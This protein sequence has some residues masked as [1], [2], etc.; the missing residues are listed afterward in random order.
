MMMRSLL[1]AS[2]TTGLFL[3]AALPATANTPAAFDRVIADADNIRREAREVRE[4][5][6]DRR[7]SLAAVNDRVHMIDTRAQALKASVAEFDATGLS[8]AQVT[9][10]DRARS[11]TDTLLALLNNKTTLL[12][13]AASAERQ[14]GLLRAKAEGIAKRAEI[15]GQEM[16]RLRS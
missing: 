16:A 10:L 5:L 12:A 11:A 8:A 7:T 2:L 14:R 1:L 15:V 4:M 9:A 6:R 3:S 13:D